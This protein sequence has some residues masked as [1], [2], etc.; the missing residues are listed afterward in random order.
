VRPRLR[1]AV[2]ALRGGEQQL[3]LLDKLRE[4][5]AG[6][7]ARRHQHLAAGAYTRSFLSST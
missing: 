4:A 6:V 2:D 3:E 7:A 1:A 5:A